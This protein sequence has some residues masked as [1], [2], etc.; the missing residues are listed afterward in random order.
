MTSPL[1][2]DPWRGLPTTGGLVRREVVGLLLTLLGAAVLLWVLATVDWR[3][4]VGLVAA[5]VLA[6][7][8]F[9]GRVPTSDEG[10]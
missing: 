7:G 10:S 2:D 6:G 8:L 3:L 9:L 1:D 4:P 5:A